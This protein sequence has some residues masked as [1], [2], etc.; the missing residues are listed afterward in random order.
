MDYEFDSVDAMELKRKVR[1]A[2]RFV[3]VLAFVLA[4]I[5]W[6][7]HARELGLWG[8]LRFW[9]IL[10]PVLVIGS[11]LGG[12]RAMAIAR[13]IGNRGGGSPKKKDTPPPGKEHMLTR[14]L[15]RATRG[16]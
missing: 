7:P 1:R 12:I 4:I 2:M 15:T 5:V 13:S 3:N 11:W 10:L 6:L 8:S 9:A 16:K 14:A